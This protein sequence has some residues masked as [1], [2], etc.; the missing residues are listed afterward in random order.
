MSIG[1]CG[2][3]QDVKLNASAKIN[4][5]D[6]YQRDTVEVKVHA[7]CWVWV[8]IWTNIGRE[9]AATSCVIYP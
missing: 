4:S 1:S 5:A 3:V 6:L 8:I 9:D 2:P 7:E